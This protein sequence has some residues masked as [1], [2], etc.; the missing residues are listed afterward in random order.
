MPDDGPA[1]S[2]DAVVRSG[3]HFMNRTSAF[4]SRLGRLSVLATIFALLVAQAPA[5]A[6][7]LAPEPAANI[8]VG[9]DGRYVDLALIQS[10]GGAVRGASE[11]LGLAAVHVADVAAFTEF[12]LLHDSVA[13]VETNDV[14]RADSAQ[15]D[16][17]QWDSTGWD[18][19]Q[20]DS[21]QW[22]SAQWDSAQWDSAQWDEAGW[23]SAQW[24][25]T[26]QDSAQWDSA[27]WDESGWD[28]AQW[29]SAQWD[30]A[31]WDSAQWDSAQWDSAQ[32]DSA[33]WDSA[34]W[35][36]AQWDG[37]GWDGTGWDSRGYNRTLMTSYGRTQLSEGI[38][39]LVKWQWS[40]PAIN[41]S[42]DV[43]HA[44][45]SSQ[46]ICI[47]DS[48][49]D[50]THQDLAPR[51]WRAADGSY[52]YDFVNKDKDPMDDGGH[53]THVAGIAAAA[54]GNG[55]G[56]AGSAPARLMAAKV[57]GAT[58]EGQ[59]FDLALG[60]DWCANNGAT[61]IS[62]SLGTDQNSKAVHRAVVDA[63]A[64]GVV[65]VAS[66]GNTGTSCD[67]VRYPAAY[68]QVLAI[69]AVMPNGGRAPYSAVSH[70]VDFVAPGY[71]IVSTLPG[72]AYGAAHGTSQAV[73][74]VSAA[75]AILRASGATAPETAQALK[76]T[77]LDLGP[78][79]WDGAFGHGAI[80][81]G[82]ALEHAQST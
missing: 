61:V 49:I 25:A 34:Q 8:I 38:D 15:W 79:G 46:N 55:L 37:I 41:L 31:Q 23:N 2:L 72:D 57:L 18:S 78:A 14:T 48:G 30:S 51:M 20:W 13:W 45:V 80:N 67:C 3:H 21:A 75:A 24:D 9:F 64:D 54:A 12:I 70:G 42:Y 53:G 19:A 76:A 29:D 73:P 65:M 1:R 6:G 59:E 16:S 7:G 74:F 22:D 17:A 50:Y 69:G 47:V 52:G 40:L 43:A 10:L 68:P 32:W 81:I 58:G 39:P 66:V 27:Q 82:A 36:S 56:L 5:G 60:I 63:F 35:D 33:Q 71:A 77:A 62:M 26:G 11:N 4:G 44:P 28:S